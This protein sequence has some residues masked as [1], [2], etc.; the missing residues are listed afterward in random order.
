MAFTFV[1]CGAVEPANVEK[2]ISPMFGTWVSVMVAGLT[3]WQA[4]RVPGFNARPFTGFMGGNKSQAGAAQ[5][6]FKKMDNT[7]EGIAEWP[8]GKNWQGT[9]GNPVF[10][11]PIKAMLFTTSPSS[12]FRPAVDDIVLA[13]AGFGF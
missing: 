8:A 5:I 10:A 1:T 7:W 12:Q 9:I 3:H 6:W 13:P 2:Y 4:F 11:E